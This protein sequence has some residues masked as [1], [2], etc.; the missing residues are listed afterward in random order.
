MAKVNLKKKN[1]FA[2]AKQ[3]LALPMGASVGMNFTQNE[4]SASKAIEKIKI[5]GPILELPAK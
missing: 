2:N 1:L 4:L 3:K 5:L